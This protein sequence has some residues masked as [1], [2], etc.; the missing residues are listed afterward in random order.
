MTEIIKDGKLVELTYS[1]ID[2]KSGQELDKVEFPINYVHG[3]N[4]ILFP[5]V[6]SKLE[7]KSVGNEIDVL[8]DCNQIFGPRDEKLVVTDNIENVPEE[9]R[10]IG[11]SISMGNDKGEVKNFVVTHLDQSTLTVDGNNPLCGR[12]IIFKLKILKVREATAEEIEAGWKD[13]DFGQT[14]LNP[15]FISGMKAYPIDLKKN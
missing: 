13:K 7:G 9:Y 15:E 4:D 14:A 6:L 10:I 5:E 8:I 3:Y 1:L 2:A 11:T 12:K